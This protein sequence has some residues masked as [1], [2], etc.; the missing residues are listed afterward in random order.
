MGFT[1][2][3]KTLKLTA[4]DFKQ[5]DSY[6]KDYIGKEDVSNYEGHIEIDGNL[7]WVK[8]IRLG[9]SGFISASAGGGIEAGTAIEAG[10]GI[11]AGWGIEAG[12]GIKAGLS[13]TCKLTLKINYNIF[14]G[15]CYRRKYVSDEDKTITC[16]KFEGGKV[17]YGILKEIGLPTDKIAPKT[18]K[19]KKVKVEIDGESYSATLD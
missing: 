15:I 3:M 17:E 2:L 13:I 5:S 14:A 1:K 11:E 19:G 12:T 18:L 6:W 4:N 16:G 10:E 9:A 7:G 8:F